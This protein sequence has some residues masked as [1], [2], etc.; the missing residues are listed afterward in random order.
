M[1]SRLQEYHAA[2]PEGKLEVQLHGCTL[3]FSSQRIKD[4]NV[5]LRSVEGAVTRIHLHKVGSRDITGA[6]LLGAYDALRAVPQHQKQRMFPT[7]RTS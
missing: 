6:M 4:G 5:N 3:E 7:S 2:A 1:S